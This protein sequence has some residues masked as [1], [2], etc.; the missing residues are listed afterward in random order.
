MLRLA[1]NPLGAGAVPAGASI[2]EALAGWRV[3]MTGRGCKESSIRRMGAVV[4]ALC[5]W[6]GWEG[7]GEMTYAGTLEWLAERR[8]AGWKGST[9]NQAVSSLKGFGDFC[10]RAKLVPANPF[11]DIRV[12]KSTAEPG[13]RAESV[14]GVRA[15]LAASINRHLRDRRAKGCAPLM[16]YAMAVSGLRVGSFGKLEGAGKARRRVGMRWRDVDLENSTYSTDPEWFKGGRRLVL[17]LYPHLV[18]MLRD[19]KA[20][21]QGRP[22]DFVF[23]VLAPRATFRM[24]REAAGL[25]ERDAMGLPFTIHGLRQSFSVWLDEAG[26][27]SGARSALLC[28]ADTLAEARYNHQG[29]E[30]LRA[31]LAKLPDPWPDG[32]K[33]VPERN[34][35]RPETGGGT[36]SLSKSPD[37]S[38]KSGKTSEDVGVTQASRSILQPLVLG[39]AD[40]A[41]VTNSSGKD[42]APVAAHTNG[43]IVTDRSGPAHCTQREN[44]SGTNALD[45]AVLALSLY[46]R[47]RLGSKEPAD[48]IDLAS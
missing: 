48:A 36:K 33:C 15:L 7:V 21:N 24:D 14:E 39:P 27:P 31:E 30:T 25:R 6:A 12:S 40:P 8:G 4:R 23:P 13:S 11:A 43:P 34:G 32:Q 2:A 1:V 41:C 26:V 3:E 9:F 18:D 46:V 22:D 42:P 5:R 38:C 44:E 16:W 28:H 29:L 47:S 10:R 37:F 35:P 19:W 20:T 45:A 17:P